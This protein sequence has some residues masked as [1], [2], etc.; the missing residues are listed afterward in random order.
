MKLSLAK[1][2]ERNAKMN[3]QVLQYF[4]KHNFNLAKVTEYASTSGIHLCAIYKVLSD[5]GVESADGH[6][7]RL[8]EFYGM[9]YDI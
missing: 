5:A 6:I 2:L 7:R 3:D 8:C 1:E 4:T 9:E